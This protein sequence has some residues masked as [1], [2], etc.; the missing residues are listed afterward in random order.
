MNYN[1]PIILSL[2]FC[3][4][5]QIKL[6]ASDT[7]P[8]LP[9]YPRNITAYDIENGL[10]TSSVANVFM[11]KKGS[12]WLNPGTGDIHTTLDFYQYDGKRSY[13]PQ[14]QGTPASIKAGQ[15]LIMGMTKDGQFF[16]TRKFSQLFFWFEPNSQEVKFFSVKAGE[17]I[18]AFV[19]GPENDFFVLAASAK[20]YTIYRVAQGELETYKQIAIQPAGNQA[21]TSFEYFVRSGHYLYF[22]EDIYGNEK[23]FNSFNSGFYRINLLDDS[24]QKYNWAD[25][26]EESFTFKK[27]ISDYVNF[28]IRKMFAY[29]NGKVIF[30]IDPLDEL[31]VFY[32]RAEKL[33]PSNLLNTLLKQ[34]KSRASD[35]TVYQD[36]SDQFLFQFAKKQNDYLKNNHFILQDTSGKLYNYRSILVRTNEVSRYDKEVFYNFYAENFKEQVYLAMTGGLAVADI[37]STSSAQ[38]FLEDIPMRGM[39]EMKPGYLLVNTDPSQKMYIINTALKSIKAFEEVQGCAGFEKANTFSQLHYFNDYA[40]FSIEELLIRYDPETN[41]CTSFNINLPFSKFNFINNNQ[42]VLVGKEDNTVYLFDLQSQSLSPVTYNGENL[43]IGLAANEC[44]ISKNGLLWIASLNGL[45]KV[46]LSNNSFE[47]IGLANGFADKRVMCIHEDASGKLWL[48]TYSGGVHVYNPRNGN[49]KIIDASVGLSNNTVVGILEDNKGYIWASTYNGISILSQEGGVIGSLAREDGLSTKEFNRYSYAKLTGNR[50]VFGSISGINILE[51]EKI[52]NDLGLQHEIKIYLT[53]LTYYNSSEGEDVT[54]SINLNKLSRINLPPTNRYIKL[55]YTLSSYVFPDAQRFSYKLEG[56]HDEWINI[57]NISE[58]NLANLPSG[59]YNILIKGIDYKGRETKSPLIIPVFVGEFFYKTYWFY[60]L[61]TL[62]I[63]AMAF[64]W[65]YRQKIGRKKLERELADRTKDIMRAR[66]QLVVQ[67]KLASLG[68]MTAGIAHEIKNPLNFINNFAEGSEELMEELE[69]TIQDWKQSPTDD[70]LETITEIIDDLKL[71]AKNICE[72]GKRADKIIRSMMDH[73]RT[74]KT[75]DH[76]FVDINQILDEN[77]RLMHYSHK[78]LNPTLNI[79][80]KTSFDRSVKQVKVSTQT[81]TQVLLNLLNN[82][83]YALEQKAKA[84]KHEYQP[85][86]HVSTICKNDT[87]I[88]KIRDNGPGIPKDIREKVFVPF[89]TTKPTGQGNTGLGLSIS[90]DIIV[91]E[92]NGNLILNSEEG[93]FTEFIIELPCQTR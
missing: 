82:A 12:L 68:Q 13:S 89:F 65:I 8:L 84:S 37:K 47:K 5:L 83:Y 92:H 42:V 30:M 54:Y 74:D 41:N 14:L 6:G 1:Q 76:Q 59:K 51:P 4:V 79:N 69:D 33:I 48:G 61:L 57:E 3:I 2:I 44:F 40:W 80:V 45:W 11:D 72:Q 38:I 21:W 62:L 71:S 88:I 46:D 7:I 67:E 18:R 36:H 63:S 56:H 29:G 28:S 22:F 66:D 20:N 91:Q 87:A 31:L 27:N 86:I 81:L 85:E 75:G 78:A 93:K 43:N 24:V 32:P 77:I 55:N 26:L 34:T 17:N 39:V 90:Y 9:L 35:L 23:G 70:K 50:L 49:V 60:L 64:S 73:A 53:E 19:E 58:L 15:M 52:I 10:P 25:L 16:G